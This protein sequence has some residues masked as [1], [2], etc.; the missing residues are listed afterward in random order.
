MDGFVPF[1]VSSI[2]GNAQVAGGINNNLSENLINVI[3]D[4]KIK[5]D[6]QIGLGNQGIF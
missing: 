2:I 6:Q 4:N 1:D 3:N 5:K